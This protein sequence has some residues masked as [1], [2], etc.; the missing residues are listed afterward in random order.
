[1]ARKKQLSI[2]PS[3]PILGASTM[4]Q[5]SQ[6]SQSLTVAAPAEGAIIADVDSEQS[7]GSSVAP[8]VTSGMDITSTPLVSVPIPVESLPAQID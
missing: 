4:Q 8:S 3:V 5:T 6:S 1:M 7:G 2:A